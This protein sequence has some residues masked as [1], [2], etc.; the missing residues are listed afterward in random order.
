MI[1]LPRFV[2]VGQAR[3]RLGPEVFATQGVAGE[4]RLAHHRLQFVA[5]PVI[6]RH[7]ESHLFSSLDFARQ[8]L[9][10]CLFQ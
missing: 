5:K 9:A 4:Q 10:E 8:H 3:H 7:P 1:E 6:E 2:F